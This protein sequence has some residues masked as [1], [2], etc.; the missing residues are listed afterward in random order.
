M[1]AINERSTLILNI[2][3]YDED[4]ALVVPDSATYKIDDI[5]SGTAI[6]ASTNITGLASSKDIHI[7]YTE[8]RILAEANQEEIRR[9]TV[10]FLYATSTKQGT[11][12]YDYKIKNLSGVTTP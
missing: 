1:Y 11:A 7:T 8:N 6:T 4:S 3:F 9:V 10:V 5:G 2:K 12:Y